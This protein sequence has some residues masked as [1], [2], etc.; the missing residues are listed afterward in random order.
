MQNRY[1]Y[2]TIPL[3]H[4]RLWVIYFLTFV[5][6]T[7]TI[8]LTGWYKKIRN[9]QGN[10]ILIGLNVRLHTDI[11][12]SSYFTTSKQ[13]MFSCAI[14]R[15]LMIKY[16]RHTYQQFWCFRY[17]ESKS[18]KLSYL[19]HVQQL[20]NKPGKHWWYFKRFRWTT[21]FWTLWPSGLWQYLA[22]SGSRVNT[23]PCMATRW[24]PI[25]DRVFRMQCD[26]HIWWVNIVKTFTP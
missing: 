5:H 15:E 10:P 7:C 18:L 21:T 11:D 14:V 19:T 16:I 6:G 17:V 4:S 9:W 2:V 26:I 24:S 20:A 22:S 1:V 23:T 25:D 12:M 13:F 8:I 3:S